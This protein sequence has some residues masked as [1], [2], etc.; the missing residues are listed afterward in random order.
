M[1]LFKFLVAF[2]A[3]LLLIATPNF[4]QSELIAAN[5]SLPVIKWVISESQNA[6]LGAKGEERTVAIPIKLHIES[7]VN[8]EIIDALGR[9]KFQL[10]T[11]YP[12][13]DQEVKVRMGQMDQ[14][15]YFVRVTTD[16]DEISQVVIIERIP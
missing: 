12:E 5:H 11:L 9:K 14:G 2:L 15:L 8:V 13:G 3:L 7:E 16:L 4:A 1:K 10:E 6:A